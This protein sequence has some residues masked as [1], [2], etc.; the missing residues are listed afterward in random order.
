M[1]DLTAYFIA[2]MPIKD[3]NWSMLD[4]FGVE[5]Q[6]TIDGVRNISG[7]ENQDE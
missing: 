4:G 7:K 2:C 6:V 3:R 5:H 1:P